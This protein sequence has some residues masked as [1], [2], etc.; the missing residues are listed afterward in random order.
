MEHKCKYIKRP[1]ESCT[2]NNFC[3]FPKCKR[4]IRLKEEEN[5]LLIILEDR[6]ELEAL[7]HLSE[8]N[9]L[10]EMMEGSR[11]IG[12]DWYCN[13]IIGLTEAPNICK[14]A[15]Y[16]NEIPNEYSDSHTRCVELPIDFEKVW[17]Y[18]DYMIKSFVEEILEK[19]EVKFILA[20]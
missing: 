17:Y 5:N 1:G 20:V 6:E 15:I 19:G 3:T 11:Y 2:L 14:G 12:N 18:P 4:M 10:W 13:Q 8:D 7:Q 9:I 16:Y